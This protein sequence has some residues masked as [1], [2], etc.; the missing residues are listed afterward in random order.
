LKITIPTAPARG[1]LGLELERAGATL[2]QRD[3]PGREAREVGRLAPARRGVAQA[4]LQVDGRDRRGDVA[5][6][7]WVI[8]PKSTPST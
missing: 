8:G 7:V 1:V 6:S 4:E 5:G 2:Q 3:V